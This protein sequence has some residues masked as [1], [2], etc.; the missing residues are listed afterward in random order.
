MALMGLS[1]GASG[2]SVAIYGAPIQREDSD[3][4]GS[5]ESEDCDDDDETVYPGAGE[6]PG[7]EV[8]SNCDGQDDT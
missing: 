8:D 4:D 6:T 2:C 1:L 5:D 7:D 3:G